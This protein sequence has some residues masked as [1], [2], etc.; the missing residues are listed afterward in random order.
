MPF[1]RRRALWNTERMQHRTALPNPLLRAGAALLACVAAAW[2]VGASAADR[3]RCAQSPSTRP[4]RKRFPALAATRP[5]PLRRA[6]AARAPR[7]AGF[8]L[9]APRDLRCAHHLG[10]LRRRH[11]VLHRSLRRP[12]SADGARTAA[13]V[14]QRVV[15]RPVLAAQRGVPVR[16][17]HAEVRS[18]ARAPRPRSRAAC[19]ARA[20]RRPTPSAWRRCSTN[21]TARATATGCATS[22]RTCRCSTA[23]RPRRRS[24]ARGAAARALFPDGAGG[25]GRQWPR[26][27]DD[28]Q[29]VRPELDDRGGGPDRCRSAGELSRRHVRLRGRPALRCAEAGLHARGAAARRH[30]RAHV[31]RSSGAL[32]RVDRPGAAAETRRGRCVRHDRT[33]PARARALPRV[34]A[35]CRRSHGADPHDGVGAL[36]RVAV[37]RAGAG[38]VHAH[39]HRS[40]G[41]RQ[42]RQVR[43]RSGLFEPSY[44]AAGLA[45]QV[46][47]S[48]AAQPDQMAH[49]AVL[50]C[51]GNARPR[52]NAP[53]AR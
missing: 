14:V 41:A 28:A 29:S 23:S 24:G 2:S 34:C 18:A 31:P 6:G 19:C 50:A 17:Q 53:C 12:R 49:S 42:P 21:A 15:Q 46:L 3:R 32:R 9:P 37:G 35:R 38:R 51:L 13:G 43:G 4:T 36:A 48:G 40:H 1:L 8:G 22:S 47:A 20:I 52:T 27:P 10:P 44:Q 7:L 26:Q 39:D 30:R 5:V 16:L 25:R 33:R 11:R 45:Q